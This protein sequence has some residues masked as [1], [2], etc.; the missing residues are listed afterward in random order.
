MANSNKL[1]NDVEVLQILH[2]SAKTKKISI[3]NWKL[4][5]KGG[6]LTGF[7]GGYFCLKIEAKIVG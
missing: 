4:T 6:E 7:L 1:L 2:S 3:I 5:E